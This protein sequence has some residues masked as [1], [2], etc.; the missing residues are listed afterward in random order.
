MR[1]ITISGYS[2]CGKSYTSKLL[3]GELGLPYLCAGDVFRRFAHEA[4]SELVKY[5]ETA[6]TEIDEQVNEAILEA[7][8]NGDVVIDSRIGGFLCPDSIKIWLKC[9]EEEAARRI[10]Y[11]NSLKGI[12][13]SEDVVL[14][15]IRERNRNTRARLMGRYGFDLNYL[16]VYDLV[17]DNERLP[18]EKTLSLALFF[19]RMVNED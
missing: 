11:R 14:T 16:N 6:P 2:G 4:G 3:S 13:T 1:A 10:V 15:Q 9:S 19:V 8:R 12:T 7:Y 17:I 18:P 5:A